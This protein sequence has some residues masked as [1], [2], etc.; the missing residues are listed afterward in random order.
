MA[1]QRRAVAAA[2]ERGDSAWLAVR[3]PD[4]PGE[5]LPG[6]WGLPATTLRNGESPE[7]GL[8]RLGREKLGV[9]LTPLRSLGEGEQERPDYTLDMTVYEASMAGEPRLPPRA[10]DRTSTL[11]EALGWLPAAL[12]N[13]AAAR[14]SLCCRV[15]LEAVGTTGVEE[16]T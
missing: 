15:F 8:R 12:F 11:Y 10:S 13:D 3:R 4:E 14:G 7:E 16:T 1:E 5:E 9:E 2:I 6:V